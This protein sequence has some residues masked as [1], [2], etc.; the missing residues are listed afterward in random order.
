MTTFVHIERGQWVLAFDEPYGPYL[1]AMPEHL[2]MFASRGGG[3]DSHRATEIFHIYR[4][5]DV[6]PKTYFINTDEFVAHPRSYI[7]DRQPRSHVIAAGATKEAMIDLRD[8]MF[9]IGSDASDRIEAEMYRRIESF[10]AKERAK[11]IKKIHAGFPH[12]FGKDAK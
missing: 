4:V 10:A 11:A 9:A 1:A 6:K 8:K 7:K 12:I 2:E 3:W 5:N